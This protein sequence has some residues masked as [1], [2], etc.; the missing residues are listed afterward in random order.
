MCEKIWSFAYVDLT[1]LLPEQN[2]QIN[3]LIVLYKNGDD[4]IVFDAKRKERKIYNLNVWQQAFGSYAA[5]LMF[6]FPN[7]GPELMQYMVDILNL[8]HLHDW[9][10]VYRYDI[11]FR[12]EIQENPLQVLG[13]N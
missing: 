6:K 10:L 5:V 1:E 4:D 11:T 12:I 7:R 8:G 13:Y 9:L 3:S 2:K